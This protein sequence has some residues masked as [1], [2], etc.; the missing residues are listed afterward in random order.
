MREDVEEMIMH[1]NTSCFRLVENTPLMH[2][3]LQADIGC[4]REAEGATEV[5]RVEYTCPPEMDDDTREILQIIAKVASMIR[6]QKVEVKISC[7]DY[8]HYWK[9]CREKTSY[10]I[11]GIH[12]GH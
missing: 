12:F 6:G 2:G 11:S 10:S 7:A 4:L 9:G 5:L 1:E 3:D 8:M